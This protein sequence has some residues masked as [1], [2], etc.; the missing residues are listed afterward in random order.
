[1]S[2]PPI[3]NAI[4]ATMLRNSMNCAT[5][6]P[7]LRRTI[8]VQDVCRNNRTTPQAATFTA[9]QEVQYP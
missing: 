2:H 3:V 6:T 1:M 7:T 9:L 8:R 5:L 4:A